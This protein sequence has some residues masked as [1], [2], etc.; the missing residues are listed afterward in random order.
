L[1]QLWALD[2]RAGEGGR[3]I[4]RQYCGRKTGA[5]RGVQA[6]EDRS[7]AGATTRNNKCRHCCHG[8]G[9]V[10]VVTRWYNG[11]LGGGSGCVLPPMIMDLSCIF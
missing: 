11:K 5:Q 6:G 4:G 8:E 9:A 7:S 10:A 3:D 1:A 2:C